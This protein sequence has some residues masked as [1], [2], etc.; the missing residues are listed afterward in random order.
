MLKPWATFLIG[1]AILILSHIVLSYGMRFYLTV[2][3]WV[4]ILAMAS[5]V[6]M[7]VVL[8]MS[9]REQFVTNLNELGRPLA[10]RAGCL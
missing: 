5:T 3:K 7:I 6:L 2:N 10:R 1:S 9:S 8:A 4:F